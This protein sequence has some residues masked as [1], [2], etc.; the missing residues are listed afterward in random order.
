M[1][2]LTPDAEAAPREIRSDGDAALVCLDFDGVLAP[3]VADPDA[4]DDPSSGAQR[5]SRRWA[6]RVATIA[7]VTGRPADQAVELGSLREI[8]AELAATGTDADR[9]RAVRRA[10]L[11]GLDDDRVETAPPPPGLAE[12]EARLPD[13][14]AQADATDA[15][16]EHKG[17]AIAVHTR[18]MPPSRR[19]PRPAASARRGGRGRVT[20]SRSSPDDSSSR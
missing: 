1:R 4:G 5:C 10:A 17:L 11:V 13:L 8:G 12:F 6:D 15:F 3:I 19:R 7:I 16:V 9:P 20:G 18:R 14:L 2:F